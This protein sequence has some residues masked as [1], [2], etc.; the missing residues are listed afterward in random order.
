MGDRS[1]ELWLA[2]RL[3]GYRHLRELHGLGVRTWILVGEELGREPDNEPLVRCL[4]PVA[5]I[6]E[7]ALRECEQ[8]IAEQDPPDGARSTGAGRPEP[9][10]APL[11][12]FEPAAAGQWRGPGRP[13]GAAPAG[14]D[15]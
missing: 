11:G 4:R 7:T 13:Q 15:K 1:L 14:K 9:A 8:I 10:D 6:G 3:Y 2:R 5:W 12:P